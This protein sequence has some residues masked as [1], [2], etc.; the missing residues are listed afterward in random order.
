[1]RLLV[2]IFLFVPFLSGAQAT[3]KPVIY[4]VVHLKTGKI[5]FGEIIEFNQKDGD[6]TF[7]DQY[8]RMY[9]LSR[10][11]YDFF[12]EDKIYRK[13]VKNV[14]S[15]VRA[16]KIDELDFHVGL[17]TLF[18]GTDPGFKPDDYY[19]SSNQNGMFYYTPIC[20][21][22]GF[23]KYIHRQHYVGL[24]TDLKAL[25]DPAIFS[26]YN[27]NYRFQYDAMKNNVARYIPITLSYQNL[28]D[29]ETF[30]V[31]D[32][33]M[34]PFPSTMEKTFESNVSSLNLGIGH[35]FSFIGKDLHYFNLE[36]L[37]YKGLFTK[38]TLVTNELTLPNLNY[39]TAGA[40]LKLSYHF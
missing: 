25:G 22:L 16:R 33:T 2:F 37:I 4:D 29:N 9:S 24:S 36:I 5:L 28:A 20:L 13:R 3:K 40:Q 27:F 34:P 11:M 31:P 21:S 10:E 18:A 6:L 32:L 15:L 23:G 38:H 14:D 8:N 1:M 19:L 7:R 39:Q 26:Q 17:N 35:G 12:E 30:Q